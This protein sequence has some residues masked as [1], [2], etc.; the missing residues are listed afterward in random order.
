[1]LK[2]ISFIGLLALAFCLDG[3]SDGDEPIGECGTY[4]HYSGTCTVTADNTFTFEGTVNEEAVIYTGNI[5]YE[6]DSLAEGQTVSCTLSWASGGACTPCLFD[7]GECGEQAWD[8]Y[9]TMP[10]P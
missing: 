1:M 8:A 3:C 5:L 2:S 10:S 4:Q 9:N 6:P 7:I